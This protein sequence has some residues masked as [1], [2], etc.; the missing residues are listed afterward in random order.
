MRLEYR[1]PINRQNIKGEKTK[2]KLLLESDDNEKIMKFYNSNVTNAE[3][4]RSGKV[5]RVIEEKKV[6]HTT[7]IIKEND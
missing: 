5:F 1:E 4:I 6:I 2:W 3:L 7:E